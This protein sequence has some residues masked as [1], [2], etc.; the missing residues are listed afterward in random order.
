[1]IEELNDLVICPISQETISSPVLLPSGVTVQEYVFDKLK[2]SKD[3]FNR[4]II[5]NDK[6]VNRFAKNVF[7]MLTNVS[8]MIQSKL[9]EGKKSTHKYF[10]FN[11]L[12]KLLK[13]INLFCAILL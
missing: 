10:C 9:I 1:M 13:K 8:K 6:I 4:N 7:E 2:G 3:P 12:Q 5:V 11:S